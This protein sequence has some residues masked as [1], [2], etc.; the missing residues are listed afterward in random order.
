[1]SEPPDGSPVQSATSERIAVHLIWEGVLLVLAAALVGATL[2]STPEAH[3]ADLIRPAGFL[4]LIAAGLAL[5]LRTGT[6]NLAVGSIAT[7][8]GVIGA[9]LASA[10]GWS[11]WAA[12]TAAVALAAAT[13]LAAGLIVGALSVPAW[14]VTLAVGAPA[15]VVFPPLGPPTGPAS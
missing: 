6:P 7:V 1:V 9:H 2:A 5:S 10:D 11:L 12:M 15:G 13:G 14:A 3:F 4:G 8:T